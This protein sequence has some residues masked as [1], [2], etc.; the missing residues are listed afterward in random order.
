VKEK[1]GKEEEE[2]KEEEIEEEEEGGGGR[3]RKK[4]GGRRGRKEEDEK[5]KGRMGGGGGRGGCT[6]TCMRA[7]ARVR[8][9]RGEEEEEGMHFV[10]SADFLE[11][12]PCAASNPASLRY[13]PVMVML[14]EG[15]VVPVDCRRGLDAAAD[16]S[17]I[18]PSIDLP[19]VAVGC[20]HSGGPT[21]GNNRNWEVSGV[22]IFTSSYARMQW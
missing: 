6:C 7:R 15:S 18:I 20:I 14:G 4:E 11:P 19:S 21:G 10:L 16:D 3:R 22:S 1:D 17:N 5:K 2:E 9:R 12:S 13:L 8:G